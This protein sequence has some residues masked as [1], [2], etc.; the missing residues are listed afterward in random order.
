MYLQF[1]AY[2][3]STMTT[4]NSNNEYNDLKDFSF[5]N[6]KNLKNYNFKFYIESIQ[7]SVNN[8]N[9]DDSYIID[10]KFY[11][12][13]NLKSNSKPLLP[14]TL[15]KFNRSITYNDCNNIDEVNKVQIE[16]NLLI[17]LPINFNN[18]PLNSKLELNLLDSNERHLGGCVVD[19]FSNNYKLKSSKKILCLNDN[20]N[21]DDLNEL[22]KFN[23]I[24][25]LISKND[26]NDLNW[27]N[28]LSNERISYLNDHNHIFNHNFILYLHLPKFNFPIIY[29]EDDYLLPLNLNDFNQHQL[30]IQSA[31]LPT[32]DNSNFISEQLSTSIVDPDND[33]P[34][35]LEIKHRRLVRSHSSGLLDREL[36]PNAKIRDE[37]NVSFIKLK[38]S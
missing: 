24:K 32:N 25:K 6:L 18:L 33:R 38:F 2:L 22:K 15:T 28:T 20:Y 5:Y 23:K 19:L 16:F 14:T 30:Q 3:Y 26:L 21:D 37:L 8:F 36:K 27:L 7:I 35:P 4:T 34:N 29:N 10:D 12:K 1:T 9:Y 13:V 11:F 17:D 31:N